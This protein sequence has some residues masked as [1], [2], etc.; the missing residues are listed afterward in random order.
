VIIHYDDLTRVFMTHPATRWEPADYDES[1]TEYYYDADDGLVSDV[2]A[3]KVDYESPDGFDDR[4]ELD[5][6]V[7]DNFDELCELHMDY[8]REYFREAAEKEMNDNPPEAPEP[9]EPED[10]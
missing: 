6:Y 7:E 5:A 2:L 8:L 3:D 4:N 10:W 9:L 1:E